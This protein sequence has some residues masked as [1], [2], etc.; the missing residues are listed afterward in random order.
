MC[1]GGCFLQPG[2]GCRSCGGGHLLLCCCGGGGGCGCGGSGCGCFCLAG[3]A[4]SPAVY[5]IFSLVLYSVTA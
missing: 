3:L 2:C 1:C 4:W 5:S